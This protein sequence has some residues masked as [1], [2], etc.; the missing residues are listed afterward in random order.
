MRR[1]MLVR[2]VA[3]RVKVPRAAKA[4]DRERQAARARW[5]HQDATRFLASTSD[6]RLCGALLLSALGLR[7][8]E[9][10]GLTWADIDLE[11]DTPIIRVNQTRT[12]V[13]G[14]VVTKSTK[15][16]AGKRTLP[17]PDAV[18][19]A[20]KATRRHQ[21]SER[22]A[23]G[24]AYGASGHLLCD[25]LGAPLDPAK[26][27]RRLRSLM[28]AAEVPVV[29]PYELRHTCLSYLANVL[30]VP[31]AVLGAWAGHTDPSFTLSVYVH[32]EEDQLV[33][34]AEG[35]NAMLGASLS[36]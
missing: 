17:L 21:A 11:A 22:L 33:S 5:K 31:P 3:E 19:T 18:V 16:A 20:L 24:P 15:T 6:N 12:L 25:E 34:A 4:A 23:A 28:T 2:N 14:K 27:R 8:A 35:L 32:A 36:G 1:Q 9:V 29:R 10:C 13:D 26:Y 7:P 30:Q